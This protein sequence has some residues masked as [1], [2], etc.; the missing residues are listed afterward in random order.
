MS[1]SVF[2]HRAVL[3]LSGGAFFHRAVLFLICRQCAIS[4]KFSNGRLLF[5]AKMSKKFRK[6]CFISKHYHCQTRKIAIRSE[7]SLSTAICATNGLYTMP[8]SDFFYLTAIFSEIAFF[9]RQYFFSPGGGM[10]KSVF[11]FYWAVLFFIGRCFFSLGGAFFYR[12]V[13]FFIGRCF[14]VIWLF[15]IGGAFFHIYRQC[16][17]GKNIAI[18]GKTMTLTGRNELSKPTNNGAQLFPAAASEIARTEGIFRRPT[19]KELSKLGNNCM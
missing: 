18:F 16:H 2:F 6:R 8:G 9:I 7:K 19:E 15:F 14:F 4:G 13:L 5:K 10:T 3:F 11:F 1:K 12:A 17:V